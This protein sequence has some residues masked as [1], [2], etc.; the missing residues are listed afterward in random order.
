MEFAKAKNNEE[1]LYQKFK[2]CAFMMNIV[3]HFIWKQIICYINDETSEK[4]M[5]S[6]WQKRSLFICGQ[7]CMCVCV[8]CLFLNGIKRRSEKKATEQKKA[9]SKHDRTTAA[10]AAKAAKIQTVHTQLKN[11]LLMNATFNWYLLR[12]SQY[13]LIIHGLLPV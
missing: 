6:Q 7:T 10:T 13:L 4:R 2:R 8:C 5:T 3:W 9:T 12:I 1:S 11:A